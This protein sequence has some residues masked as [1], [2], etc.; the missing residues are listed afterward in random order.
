MSFCYLS[1]NFHFGICHMDDDFPNDQNLC[2]E[3]IFWFHHAR[4]TVNYFRQVI[5]MMVLVDGDEY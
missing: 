3:K 2:L 1:D 5:L 4:S